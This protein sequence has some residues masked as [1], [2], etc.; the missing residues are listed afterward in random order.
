[1][2]PLFAADRAEL[3]FDRRIDLM[4]GT[5]LAGDAVVAFRL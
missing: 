3:L 5:A 2:D 1:M 4:V